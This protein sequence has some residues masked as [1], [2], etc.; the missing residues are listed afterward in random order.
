MKCSN[1]FL[2]QAYRLSQS[3]LMFFSLLLE[4]LQHT[5][6]EAEMSGDGPLWQLGLLCFCRKQQCRI[7]Q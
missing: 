6:V 5:V 1:G 2:A 4:D 3:T 7:L